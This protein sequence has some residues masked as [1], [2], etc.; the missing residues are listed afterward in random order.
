M[1]PPNIKEVVT[2]PLN[3][4]DSDDEDEAWL[5]QA[6][7]AVLNAMNQKSAATPEQTRKEQR[8]LTAAPQHFFLDNLPQQQPI[9]LSR[10]LHNG[11]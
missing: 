5:L 11:R 4:M 3:A 6:V 1:L 7:G 9:P 10:S 8:L 2:L